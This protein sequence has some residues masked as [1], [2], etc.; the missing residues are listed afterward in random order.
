M[1]KLSFKK[2]LFKTLIY[3]ALYNNTIAFK[4]VAELNK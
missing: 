3:K 1:I 4:P 2:K